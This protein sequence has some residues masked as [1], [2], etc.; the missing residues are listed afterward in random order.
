M[1]GKLMAK[2]ERMKIKALGIMALLLLAPL[3]SHA[4]I[5]LKAGLNFANVTSASGINAGSRSGFVAGVFFGSPPMG[6][7]GFRSEFLFSRQGYDFGSNTTTGSVQLDY[8]IMPSL[9]VIN[10]GKIAQIQAGAQVSYLLKANVAGASTGD[11]ATDKIMDLF[12]RFDYGL[13][14]GLEI[15]PFKGFLI[16]A[17]INLSF[18]NMY[19]DPTTFA[20]GTPSFFPSVDAKN[21]VF[22][23]YTGY[24][25]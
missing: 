18:G 13:A 3:F 20:G 9:M 14:G 15:T 8:I 16:G 19:K 25:F 10:L 23:L 1:D 6:L 5:G 24:Q 7:M 22:Q 12:N 21:N 11:P 4:G 17:R 2:G